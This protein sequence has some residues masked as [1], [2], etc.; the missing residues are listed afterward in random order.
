MRE[1]MSFDE[2]RAKLKRYYRILDLLEEFKLSSKDIV[3]LV[4]SGN[5]HSSPQ[6]REVVRKLDLMGSVQDVAD[7]LAQ[8]SEEQQRFLE[9]RF[10]HEMSLRILARE[11]YRSVGALYQFERDTL[12]VFI[13]ALGKIPA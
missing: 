12:T 3:V 1:S 5:S 7:A 9:R 13:A 4:Y 10:R 6:E 2:A 11:F 8:L